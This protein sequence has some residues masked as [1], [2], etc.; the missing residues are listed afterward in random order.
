M[1]WAEEEVNLKRQQYHESAS[2]RLND[3][4]VY[5]ECKSHHMMEKEKL[6]QEEEVSG[7]SIHSHNN[8]TFP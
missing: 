5:L 3:I 6:H 7:V 8:M 2:K 1:A 4:R